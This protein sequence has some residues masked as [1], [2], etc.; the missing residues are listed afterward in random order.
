MF[1]YGARRGGTRQREGHDTVEGYGGAALGGQGGLAW[2]FTQV[3][4]R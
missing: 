1:E 2:Y 4:G 3:R